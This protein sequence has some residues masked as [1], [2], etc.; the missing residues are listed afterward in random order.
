M[1][2]WPLLASLLLLAACGGRG[3]GDAELVP[4]V[5]ELAPTLRY[6]KPPADSPGTLLEL[7]PHLW[8]ATYKKQGDAAGIHAGKVTVSRL[9][10]AELD[11]YDFQEFGEEA[12][13]FE[14]RRVGPSLYRRTSGDTRFGQFPGLPGA[15]LILQRSLGAWRAVISPYGDH[16]AYLRGEDTT[17]DGRS[18]RV[19]SLGLAPQVAPSSESSLS[20][21]AAAN[22][23]GLAVTPVDLSGL[24]YIDVETGNRLLAE[25][26]GSFVP[27]RTVGNTDPSDAVQFTYRESRSVSQ[28]AATILPPAA[29]QVRPSK[30]SGLAFP[31]RPKTRPTRG[32]P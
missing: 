12:L 24:L 30:A 32:A 14:E 8:E 5:G 11:Y 19:Y 10:W 4:P 18:V 1:R 22:L 29:A 25:I 2:S 27:R 13:R 28:L 16:V 23:A 6:E 20:L 26:Q 17:I 31:R 21:E 3:C 7:G 9:V 15:T